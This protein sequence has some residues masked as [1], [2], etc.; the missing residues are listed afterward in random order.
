[1]AQNAAQN[2][3]KPRDIIATIPVFSGDQLGCTF[4]E[5]RTACEDAKILLTENFEPAFTQMLKTK[6][7]SEV[8]LQ[9]SQGTQFNSINALLTYLKDIFAPRES[10]NS[11]RGE[12]GRL[13]QL[14]EEEVPSYL[15]RARTLGNQ[16]LEAFKTEHNNQITEAQKQEINKEVAQAFLHGL[17]QEISMMI[18]DYNNLNDAGLNAIKIESKLNAQAKLRELDGN[19]EK[20]TDFT[21]ELKPS[22]S[23]PP[24]IS[25]PQSETCNYCKRTGH[26]Y[27]ECRRRVHTCSRCQQKGHFASDCIRQSVRVI[28][29]NTE[30]CQLCSSPYHTAKACPKIKGKSDIKICQYCDKKGHLATECFKVNP[31][32]AAH[33]PKCTYCQKIGHTEDI[34]RRKSNPLT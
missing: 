2:F 17:R 18:D 25:N 13:H 19:S 12:L 1:M 6:K 28:E 33:L 26:V 8:A 24:N 22:T 5:F 20:I 3:I 9:L 32:L 30:T 4:Q 7:L 34:C 10:L 21:N 23:N 11:L 16:I 14:D 15:N 29:S 27:D 31:I